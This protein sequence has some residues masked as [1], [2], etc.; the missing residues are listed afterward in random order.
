MRTSWPP[1]PPPCPPPPSAGPASPT[2]EFLM[3]RGI[4][5]PAAIPLDTDF[6][7]LNRNVMVALAGLL[8]AT[9]GT[10]TVAD[11]LACTPTAPA[12]LTVVVGPGSI[13]QL[14]PLD[15]NAYGSLAA[16]AADQIV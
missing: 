14:G 9:L 8:Q 3:D 10:G 11:G 13:T 4:V 15:Q 7:G 12:S 16:D 5:Y 1:S 6:L 2:E